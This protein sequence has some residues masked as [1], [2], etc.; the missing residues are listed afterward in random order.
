MHWKIKNNTHKFAI[1]KRDLSQLDPDCNSE[2]VHWSRF[3]ATTIA[4]LLPWISAA[5]TMGEL[6]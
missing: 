2:I 5:K 4:V 3:K 1:Q 6:G